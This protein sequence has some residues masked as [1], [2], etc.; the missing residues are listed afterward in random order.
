MRA[1]LDPALELYLHTD[2]SFAYPGFQPSD[3]DRMRIADGG[4]EF[5]VTGT[6]FQATFKIEL[7]AVPE[8]GAPQPI[9]AGA[10][11][12]GGS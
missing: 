9:P 8:V 12:L 6:G 4:W 1:V 2:E 10:S 7:D 3:Q 5:D 11:M